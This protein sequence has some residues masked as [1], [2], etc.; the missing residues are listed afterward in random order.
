MA[1]ARYAFVVLAV[2]ALVLAAPHRGSRASS[3]PEPALDVLAPGD[4][5]LATRE[6]AV[7][8]LC[9][10][11]DAPLS[12]RL[13]LL[14]GAPREYRS[15]VHEGIDFPAPAGAPVRAAAAGT[16]VRIDREY[17]EWSERERAAALAAAAR[18]GATP[19]ETLDRIRGRQVWIDHGDGIVTRY[20]HLESVADLGVGDRLEAGAVVGAVG[21]S[22]LPEGGAHL[23]FEIRVDDQ[24]LG[25]DL[26]PDEILYVLA[27]AFSPRLVY[28]ER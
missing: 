21:A 11:V 8:G 26:A 18:L 9:V 5:V 24:Y 4:P 15:G 27:R 22:G 6:V 1:L 16:I 17:A 7:S 23:H 19:S 14:P 2:S 28:R 20:A 3:P 25:E 10:P 13:E 12:T